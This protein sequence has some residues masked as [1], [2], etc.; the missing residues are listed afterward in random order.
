MTGVSRPRPAA[1]RAR[2]AP[3]G[4]P[5]GPTATSTRPTS[6]STT[7]PRRRR[8]SHRRRRRDAPGHRPD[9]RPPRR[10]RRCP[11]LNQVDGFDCQGC[12]WPDPDPATGT[13]PSSART[14][15]RRSPRRRPGAA[16][17]AA[18]FAD[19]L[20][21]RP[22]ASKTDYWLGQQGRL[23]E[24]MVL[25][26]GAH[27]LRADHLGRRVRADRP[28]TCAGS[29]SPDEA[30]FYTSGKTSNE[31][32]FVYQLFVRAFG[33]NNLPD[34]SNMCHE[35][36]SVGARRGDRH[37]QGLG[38]PRGHPRGRADRDRRARTPAPTTRGCSPRSRSPSRTARR[39]S[40]ST[41]C[42]RP[43]WSASR[44]RRTPR[45]LVGARHRARRPAPAGPGQRRP[46]ALPGDRRR[47][48][49]SG[50]RVDHDFIERAHRRLRRVRRARAPSSTGTRSSAPPGSTARADRGGGRGCS[51]TPPR[52]SPAG[53]W[54]SPSTATRSPRSRRSSTSRCCRATSASPAPGSARSAATPTCRATAPWASGSGRRT[55]FLD[56]L[57]DEFGFEPPRE[58]GHDTV[59]AIRALRDGKAKVFFAMGGNFVV[60]R[61]RH[62]GHRG[63]RC[64]TPS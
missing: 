37:R 58:H 8:G 33:T 36:T 12:A 41:R 40:R 59:D 5:A 39:S 31:A 61:A 6:R 15:P 22:G 2:R 43:G 51:A 42:A 53:R 20:G 55:H 32:A 7:P 9:G 27:P 54:A 14:A 10:R 45:G 56:A 23:T 21:R 3:Q 24:P 17:T 26:A 64:A 25:R 38:H 60:R 35:S 1:S 30:I 4:V 18:F 49:S 63:R 16:S 29:A 47:C 19:A 52:P 50:T 44:T 11:K 46:R 13:P 28:A 34:C 48:C 62:R 57:R